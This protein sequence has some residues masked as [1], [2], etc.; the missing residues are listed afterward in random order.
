[1]ATHFG[2][3][4]QV[5]DLPAIEAAAQD[6]WEDKQ[7][8]AKLREQNRDGP[9]HSFVDGPI[10]ANNPMGVHHAWG[11]TYK[12][13]YTR[14]KAMGG[15]HQRYQNGFDCQGLWVEVEVERELGL[16]SKR[17]IEAYG[18]DR[19]AR[20]CAARVER[21]GE[22]I[23]GQSRRLG[24]W[25]DWD[26]S[27]YTHSDSNIEHIWHFLKVCNDNG[28]LRRG[29]RVMPWCTR[30]GTSLSQHELLGTDTYQELTHT[31]VTLALPI[32]Q[33]EGEHLLVWTTTP[34]TLAGNVACAVAPDLTYVSA[35]LDG[36]RYVLARAA[37]DRVL[38]PKARIER[39]FPGRELLGLTYQGPWDELDPQRDVPRRI[40]GWEEVIGDEGTGIVHIA[41]GSGAED[42]ELGQR[43]GLPALSIIDGEGAYRE[44]YGELAGRRVADS[45]AYIVDRLKA[46]GLLLVAGDHTHRYPVC[47]RCKEEIVFNLVDEW[48]IA[49]EQIR[50]RM[51][52]AARTV[53]WVPASAGARM[54]DWLENM[55]D[56]AISRKRYWGL[57]LPFYECP[58][59]GEL[60]VIGSLA[61]LRARAIDP[62][63]VD[64]LRELHRPWIDEI[65]IAC[66][67]GAEL[68]RV[69]E[70][71]DCWLD[72][73]IVP[74]STLNYLGGDQ[75]DPDSP[76]NQ[77]F[78]ADF[79]TEM[80]EQIRL[81]FYSMLFMSVAI[82]DRAPYRTCFVYEKVMDQNGQAMHRS[83]G[84]SI[85][86]DEAVAEMGADVMRWMYVGTNPNANVRFGY[87]PARAVMRRLLT[88]WNVYAFFLTY[89]ELDQFDPLA[90][91][92]PLGSRPELDR[93]IISRFNS[94]AASVQLAYENYW[95]YPV[96][97][98]LE[99]FWDDLSNWY[100]RLCRRRY[101][102]SQADEDK[103]AAYATLYEVLTGIVR[104]MAP[105][106]PHLAEELYQN[107][108]AHVPGAPESVFLCPFAQ[109]RPERIDPELEAEFAVLRTV[110]S[111][112]RAARS[113][114]NLK[115]R[116]PLAE[117]VVG[118][119]DHD[120]RRAIERHRDLVCSEV[121]VKA[122]RVTDSSSRLLSFEIKPNFRSLGP[123]FGRSIGAAAAAIA[124]LDPARVA[125]QADANEEIPIELAGRSEI[126]SADD[127][128]IRYS[129]IEG[130][131]VAV[132]DGIAVGLTTA[133][134]AKLRREGLSREIVHAIQGMRRSAGYEISDRI[135]V[136]LTGPE[137]DQLLAEHGPEIAS[138]VLAVSLHPIRLSDPEL[139][140]PV[141][142]SGQKYQVSLARAPDRRTKSPIGTCDRES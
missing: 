67:C 69:K 60:T 3:P 51:I 139:S 94:L 52:A 112:G 46:K 91:A 100:V 24:M 117:L 22:R 8:F 41:P 136:S 90:A 134:D 50:P 25:M 53:N 62:A 43:E 83:F 121:N 19:F 7:V 14:Y 103:A 34:W 33:R 17:E 57:P 49:C 86:F 85:D 115:T 87:Q 66:V 118:T 135:E 120:A 23:S 70:V 65:R 18:L 74:F 133:I 95:V 61:H 47:W 11:R 56:W 105:L 40:V 20:A 44:D 4:A 6:F 58:D 131:A 64:S 125:A 102:K 63:A 96:V 81:W 73:G 106:A 129:G 93:W 82:A 15:F 78:P 30:C 88:L 71:G 137:A 48:F 10:T 55:G 13:V 39:E 59:C 122:L 97:G 107:L 2:R 128:V 92:P 98:Q 75:A 101:W 123:R 35:S 140:Q 31:A 99:R 89:A 104:L 1:M 113:Q 108:E 72:A 76:W 42:F 142:I 110:I 141:E 126:L 68:E 27:Y 109:P 12:D 130:L 80:R 79:I 77:W 26:D 119:A 116:Q 84:N 111:L 132:D 21:F 124:K 114:A 138:E 5:P 16:N 127:L 9:R 38:G 36:K 54:V 29:N 37:L 45:T 28:W 32:R